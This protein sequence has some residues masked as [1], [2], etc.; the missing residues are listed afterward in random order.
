MREFMNITKALSD[1]NRVRM[2]L[3]LQHGELCACQLT[4]LLGLAPS[5]MSK[6]LSIL[7][8]AQ[9]VNSRKDGRWV[10][11]ALPGQDAPPCIQKALEWL[12]SSLAGHS[13]ITAD[14]QKLREVLQTDPTELCRRQC[15][16]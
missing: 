2:L 12:L 9:L 10:Y 8:Q 5:T 6:H 1:A 3:A 11:Y 15:R 14:S 7:F 4:E 16:A 13:Q